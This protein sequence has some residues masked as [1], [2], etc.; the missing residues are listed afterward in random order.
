M[1]NLIIILDENPL[2]DI[3]IQ[4]DPESSPVIKTA[5]PPPLPP[6]LFSTTSPLVNLKQSSLTAGKNNLKKAETKPLTAIPP[7]PLLPSGPPPPPPPFLSSGPPPPPPQ[8]LENKPQ[9]SQELNNLIYNNIP[10][11]SKP[12]KNLNWQQ[13]PKG[14]NN[15]SNIWKDINQNYNAVEFDF[16]MLEELFGKT[17]RA[18]NL[19]LSVSNPTGQK[20]SLTNLAKQSNQDPEFTTFLDSK[21]TMSF[22]IFLK[23]TKSFKMEKLVDLIKRGK[24]KEIGLDNLICLKKILPDKADVEEIQSY[25]RD[26]PE[27]THL[28]EPDQFIKRLSDIPSYELRI[29]LMN[30]LEE[31][32]DIYKQINSQ[33]NVYFKS[34]KFILENETLRE[35]LSMVL[36]LGNFLNANS[37]KGSTTGFKISSLGTLQDLKA[38]KG[39]ITSMNFLVEQFENNHKQDENVFDFINELKEL[40][41][42]LKY[43]FI[44]IVF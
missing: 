40:G 1:T 20:F 28:A 24:S 41:T 7:A 21:S 29:K 34:T 2:I 42:V 3:A 15:L 17:K 27:M 18:S 30:F 39:S 23:K 31:F 8:T 36:R 14:A 32:D 25:C 16:S 4:T 33:I 43:D 19:G 38:N 35:I 5:P 10:K 12:L 44:K 6:G 26:S 9:L 13:L 11:P 22:S 37:Y